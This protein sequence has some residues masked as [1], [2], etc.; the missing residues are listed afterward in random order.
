[1]Q[2]SLLIFFAAMGA[3]AISPQAAEAKPL[4]I[5]DVL[6]TVSIDKVTPSP[7]G[8]D[9]AI[10]VQRPV[11]D[12]E[13]FGRT[14][15]EIDPSRSDIWLVA[16][17]GSAKRN[18]TEGA[19]RAAGFWCAQWS[20]DGER[21][22]MLS[23]TPEGGEP[24]GG[25]A[26][27]I[28]VWERD[29][30][31]PRRLS[32]GA[33]ATQ[34]RY[35]SPLY[36]LDLR[37]ALEGQQ[38]RE[39]CRR[40]DENAPFLWLD[41][42]TLLVV[43]MPPGQNSALF[44]QQGRSLDHGTEV[45][46]K[47]LLGH[48]STVDVA[49]SDRG[50]LVREI[51][52]YTAE[53]A[54]IDVVTGRRRLLGE[55]PF[56]PVRGTLGLSVSPD[57]RR[58]AVL[59]PIGAIPPK[60]LGR[61]PFNIN[62]VQVEKRL[63]IVTLDGVGPLRWIDLP[64]SARYP[65]DLLEWSPEGNALALRARARPAEREVRLFTLNPEHGTI[66]SIAPDLFNDPNDAS[67]DLPVPAI[68]WEGDRPSL[69]R[70]RKDGE[71]KDTW[72]R[73]EPGRAAQPASAPAEPSGP[74]LPVDAE[75]LAQDTHG[76]IWQQANSQGLFLKETPSGTASGHNGTAQDILSLDSHL[77]K[78]D[79]G[80]LRL[81]EYTG[82]AGGALKGLMILP[83]GYQQGRRYPLL[84]WVYPWTMIRGTR[85]Y[86]SDYHLPGIYNLQL[87][88]ARGYAVLIPSIPVPRTSGANSI[89]PVVTDGVLPAV[90]EA[91]SLG[92]VDPKRV[93][94]FGQ[95]MGGYTVYALVTQ[96][97]RFAAAAALAGISDYTAF[98]G[99]F[100]RTAAGWPGVAQDKSANPVIAETGNGLHATPFKDPAFYAANSPITYVARVE[101][102]LL[103]AHG[104][105]DVRGGI[106][107]AEAFFTELDQQGKAARLLRYEG[108]NH[109]LAASPANIRH[110]YGEIVA[111][112]D[113][114]LKGP[115]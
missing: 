111:W 78:V 95:S 75:I 66:A 102:P 82:L 51:G 64:A 26:V 39:V 94:I 115:Q 85:E 67:P 59:T 98:H 56:F 100:D 35:G 17:D 22:A 4:D 83:P 55:I 11:S 93:G 112:F 32:D 101:T 14:A 88:A 52:R 61:L 43:Q 49:D 10:V 60:A 108:E 107:Q 7:D 50:M 87:Y 99:N 76:V 97:N 31:K 15:Y 5:E 110:L 24:R 9:L 37:S 41:A 28:Y 91:V 27:R 1:M 18:L 90:D 84:V 12:G 34:T 92:I 81:I 57:G 29:G 106:E 65:L 74:K 8:R 36:A 44:T 103:M 47:L 45:A 79:W 40:Y 80:E 89:Y 46:S 104:T 48:E 38:R 114:Y 13:A 63:A 70:G 62:D 19:A 33:M 53:I 30:G 96:T 113:K 23:T 54:V 86:W 71:T 68:A 42:R 72:W 6:K 20:P 3:V 77:A 109:S 21:L 25:N 73:I 58:L 69:I 105:H 2:P 16:R